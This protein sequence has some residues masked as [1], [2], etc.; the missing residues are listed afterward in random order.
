M[1]GREDMQVL[2]ETTVQEFRG[3]GKLESIVVKDQATGETR[4]M[5]P[6]AVFVFIGLL[7]NTDL[8]RGVVELDQYEFIITRSNLET[9]MEGVFAAGDCRV[10]STKQVVSAM[11]EGATAALMVREYLERKGEKA[12]S[13]VEIP[14]DA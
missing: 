9:S 8:L 1:A 10:G 2:T 7:P 3:K 13:P 12:R 4:E 11:G 6:G 5:R 14:A